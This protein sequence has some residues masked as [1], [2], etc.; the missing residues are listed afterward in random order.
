LNKDLNST[1]T[2]G[3]ENKND[4]SISV[5]NSNKLLKTCSRKVIK[6]NQKTK[7]SFYLPK[8]LSELFNEVFYSLKISNAPIKNKSEL[9]AFFIQ[10]SLDELKNNQNSKILEKIYN[11]NP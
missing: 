9:M 7:V 5:N 3:R 10:F 8:S 11:N 1:E 4:L 6:L 2:D